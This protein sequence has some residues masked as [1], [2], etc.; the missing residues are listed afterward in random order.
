MSLNQAN[1][2]VY[3]LLC[4][5]VSILKSCHVLGSNLWDIFVGFF[6]VFIVIGL[7]RYILYRTSNIDYVH[8]D[9]NSWRGNS[10]RNNNNSG[11]DSKRYDIR[12][13]KE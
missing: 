6:A 5:V 8:P 12:K 11:Y 4:S 3:R 1:Q 2:L 9:Y 13:S 7:A 10:R